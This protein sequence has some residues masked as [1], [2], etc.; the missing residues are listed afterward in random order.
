MRCKLWDNR[1]QL[2]LTK[3]RKCLPPTISR[4]ITDRI[5]DDVITG[6]L[7]EQKQRELLIEEVLGLPDPKE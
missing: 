2:A 7:G 4:V 6:W 3:A 1:I 5:T